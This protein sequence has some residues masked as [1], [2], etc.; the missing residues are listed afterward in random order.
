MKTKFHFVSESCFRDNHAQIS[1]AQ[2]MRLREILSQGTYWIQPT[3]RYGAVLW[4][5]PLLLSYL[6]MGADCRAH[7][8]LVAEY[9]A[10]IPT[11]A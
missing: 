11:A 1:K 8:D 10:S 7:T 5:L 2:F 4:N 3:G 6:A 9:M